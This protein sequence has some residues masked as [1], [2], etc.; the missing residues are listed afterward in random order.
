MKKLV[1]SHD[2]K[3]RLVLRYAPFHQGA[4]TI[5]R[6]LEAARRQG[7]FWETLD[8]VYA[9]QGEWADHHDPKPDVMWEY[10]PTVGLDL[11]KLREDMA[12]PETDA[13]LRQDMADVMTLG[14]RRTPT[15][16]VNGR[17]LQQFGLRELET[18]VGQTVAEAYGR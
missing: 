14:V 11:E 7:K 9:K 10:F 5:A 3:V 1:D 8:L 2:G 13:V 4:D 15:F 18:L 16:L 17:P 12:T 6:S